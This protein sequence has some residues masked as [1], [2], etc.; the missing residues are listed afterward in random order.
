LTPTEYGLIAL[1]EVVALVL[2]SV[3]SL[4]MPAII[5]FYYTE[6]LDPDRR[7]RLMGTILTGVTLANIVLALLALTSGRLLFGYLLPSVPF[8][9]YVP[10]VILTMLVEP[11]WTIVGVVLQMQERAAPYAMLSTSRYF[12]S[13]GLRVLFVVALGQGVLGFITANLF[14]AIAGAVTA[15]VFLKRE[16][17][18]AF[19]ISEVRRALALGVPMVPNNLLSYSFRLIDRVVLERVAT[20]DQIGL[21]YLGLRLAEVMRIGADVFVNAWRPVFFK[22]AASATF[23][24]NVAPQVIR[25]ASLSFIGGFLVL[26][27]F[28]REISALF[29]APA[30]RSAHVF[31]PVLAAAFTVKA[32]YAFPYLTVWYRKK[33]VYVPVLTAVTLLFSI[34]ANLVL[35]RLW[36]TYG[37]GV[38]LLLSHT[39]LFLLMFVIARRI[40]P[41]PYPFRA[42]LGGT[43][44]AIAMVV[45]AS[46]LE[47]GL[48]GSG[49]KAALLCAYP[50][51][52]TAAGWVSWV[53][54]RM[55]LTPMAGVKIPSPS[56][57][58]S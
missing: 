2:G 46:R 54:L 8:A 30:Y 17:A 33:T 56:E 7:R 26:S 16:A 3:F 45:L 29:L 24:R 28:A 43:M 31:V 48:I 27:L 55:I 50:I 35:G 5:Q 10:I 53:E 22:E 37:V 44:T 15:A 20:L 51:I 41:L 14:T 40:F 32:L 21:Y 6:R 19:E 13:M 58:V 18:P 9:P 52:L 39:V 49:L 42:M 34:G 57:A 1:L 47:P 4:G 25:L 36:G 23:C 38:A 12:L 11:Y